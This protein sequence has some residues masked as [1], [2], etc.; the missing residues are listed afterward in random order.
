MKHLLP[1]L[2]AL[3][4]LPCMAL[5]ETPTFYSQDFSLLQN[6][7]D[8]P[9]NGWKAYGNGAEPT[10]FASTLFTS[11][12]PAY[13]IF[14][15]AGITMAVANTEFADGV[16]AD[17]WLISPEIE[18]PYD[19]AALLFTAC[20]F[21][22]KANDMGVGMNNFKVLLSE[23]GDSKDDFKETLI[24]TGIRG[25]AT[26]EVTTKKLV[27]PVKGRKGSKVRVAFVVTGANVGLTGFS[28][29]SMGQYILTATNLTPE[30]SPIGSTVSVD[31]NIGLKTPVECGYIDAVL[32][33]N[34]KEEATA[35]YKKTFGS[36]TSY[37]MQMQR[38]VFEDVVT[39]ENDV[40]VKYTLSLTP[41]FEGAIPSIV[42][43]YI[44][45]PG[46]TY[47]AN[48][49]VEE[50]TATGCGYC[51]RGTAAMEYYLY[52]YPGSDTEGRAIPIAIHGFMNYFDPMSEGVEDYLTAIQTL[53]GTEALPAAI[54][55]R[56]TRGLDPSYFPE[57]EKQIGLQ[58]YNKGEIES[59]MRD[60]DDLKVKFT[61]RNGYNT[62]S[63]P[64]KAS[65]VLLE[66]N[67]K[68]TS[69]GYMQTNYF[70][71]YTSSQLEA[72]YGT[73]LIPYIKPFLADG[74][75]GMQVIPAQKMTY[76]HVARG[77]FP[78]FEGLTTQ[79]E[80]QS[81]APVEM[82]IDFR[83]PSN[84]QNPDN[85]A[86]VLLVTDPTDNS[87]VASD[88]LYAA[89]YGITSVDSLE[90]EKGLEAY[91][92]DNSLHIVAEA[93][94]MVTLFD[95]A[96]VKILFSEFASG[97]TILPLPSPGIFIVD[98]LTYGG[99]RTVQKL[100]IP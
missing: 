3:L 35:E 53:N 77:V 16:E 65:V 7:E 97:E 48:V 45:T 20:A 12:G 66:N 44:S 29:L 11:D 58:S 95:A 21:A 27:V 60:G 40:P 89:D 83:I 6:P 99:K 86:V 13:R 92:S 43:G 54:F 85:T 34:D 19:N 91:V 23:S 64:L 5:T 38:I 87:I 10:G 59:V 70:Y 88:I 39:L 78:D 15:A 82:T 56:S 37:I 4:A 47:P 2:L 63:R 51:P 14:S 62:S 69:S 98:A 94:G 96:G 46:A 50:C 30:V 42:S 26:V 41:R 75:L 57:M 25:S 17:Q 90:A 22:N 1:L 68:G 28:D 33:I 73:D 32:R 18:V 55:N 80:W 9:S 71:N 84:V 67:V 49:V 76:Q 81:D 36:P 72:M 8:F 52:K 24:E 31:V 100:L 61:I 74:E 93:S 79:E